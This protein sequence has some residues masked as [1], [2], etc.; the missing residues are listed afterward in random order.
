MFTRIRD[1]IRTAKAKDPAATST[2]EVLL[3]AGLHAVW[4][5]RLAH[6][7]TARGHPLAARALSQG[8]RLLTG[9]EIHPAAEV[10]ERLFIDH[11][12]GVVVGETADIG[13]DVLLYHGVTLGGKTMRREKRHPTLED[14]VTIGANATLIGPITVGEG[15][16]V[17]AGAVVTKDVPA[18]ATVA[19]NPARRVDAGTEGAVDG[20]GSPDDIVC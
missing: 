2:A 11:G 18:G 13:D 16:S 19:G 1:D 14:G 6:A 17:G 10:G 12:M 20:V 15:A 8:A 4:L 9:V 5:Y 3:Y 7:L